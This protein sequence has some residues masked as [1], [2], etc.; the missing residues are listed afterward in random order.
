[1]FIF[2]KILIKSVISLFVGAASTVGMKI[3]STVW[4]KCAND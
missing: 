4:D 2:K 1:M 3:A